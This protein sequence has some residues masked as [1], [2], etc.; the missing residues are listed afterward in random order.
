M[1]ELVSILVIVLIALRLGYLVGRGVGDRDGYIRGYKDGIHGRTF[2]RV[3]EG[4]AY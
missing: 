2:K 4:G 3:R 1:L